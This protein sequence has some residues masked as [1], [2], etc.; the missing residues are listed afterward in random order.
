MRIGELAAHTGLSRDTLRF[1][2][3]QGLL[4]GRRQANGY[5]DFDARSVIWLQYVRM[6]QTLGFSLAE[7]RT[8]GARIQA[9][10][11][12]ERALN[13]L[14]ADKLQVVDQR[15]AELTALRQDIAA[16]IGTAC[17]LGETPGIPFQR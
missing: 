15:L 9:A 10:P 3:K 14:L 4:E 16:R 5:R 1:Y 17:P 11:D 2:E 13:Q 7:I 8:H 6:A 12:Q